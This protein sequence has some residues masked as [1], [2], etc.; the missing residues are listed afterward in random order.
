MDTQDELQEVLNQIH[1]EDD[2][3]PVVDWLVERERFEHAAEFIWTIVRDNGRSGCS[4][5]EGTANGRTYC[6]STTVLK[7]I[8]DKSLVN[9]TKSDPAFSK[10]EAT[11]SDNHQEAVAVS[12]LCEPG[13]RLSRN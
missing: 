7:T 9:C 1:G 8:F 4:N 11:K 5:F 12:S 10:Q 2:A 13:K 3:Q 6:Q